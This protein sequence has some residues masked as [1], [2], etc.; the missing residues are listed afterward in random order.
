MRT[1]TKIFIAVS[2][3]VI[4]GIAIIGTSMAR[5]GFHKGHGPFGGFGGGGAFSIVEQ[6]DTNQDQRLSTA[7]IEEGIQSRIADADS[8][9]DGNLSLEEFQPLLVVLMKPKIVDGFQFLDAD[10]DAV[11]TPEE[12]QRPVNRVMSH[13]D[14]DEDGEL[15]LDEMRMRHRGWGHGHHGEHHDD[16][17]DR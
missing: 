5:G 15:A 1:H 10:G 12:I 8:D 3:A 14:R 13:L 2:V 7:E 4:G 11:I 17:D 6:F 16:D 9:G